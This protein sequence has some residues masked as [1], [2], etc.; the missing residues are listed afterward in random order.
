[1]VTNGAGHGGDDAVARSTI[2]VRDL[3]D[4]LERGDDFLLVDVREPYEAQIVSIPGSVLIP[5]GKFLD[6]SAM[7]TLPRDKQ[8]VLYCRSGI[9]SA[10]AL[11]IVRAAGFADA[12]HVGGGVLDW[13]RQIEPH[14]SIY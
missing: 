3:A 5:K 13:V 10:E 11:G 14:K 8:V 6:G 12:V 7:S 4:R 1:M 2:T 9:R